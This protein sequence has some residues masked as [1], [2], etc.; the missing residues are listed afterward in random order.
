MLAVLYIEYSFFY[1]H[2]RINKQ[3]N[4]LQN[5][6]KELKNNVKQ[7]PQKVKMSDDQSIREQVIATLQNISSYRQENGYTMSTESMEECFNGIQNVDSRLNEIVNIFTFF[8]HRVELV[9]MNLQPRV[10]L[11]SKL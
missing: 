5:F 11:L 9:T 1:W 4:I 8:L 3:K 10:K 7:K 2:I 6:S